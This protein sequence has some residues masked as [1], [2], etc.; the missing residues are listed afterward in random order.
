MHTEQPSW[1]EGLLRTIIETA[2]EAFIMV[3]RDGLILEFNGAAERTF[4]FARSE[5]LGRELATTIMPERYRA[6]HRAGLRRCVETGAGTIIGQRIELN[7]LHRDGD[8]F[9]VELTISDARLTGT[10]TGTGPGEVLFHAF[11]HDISER[12]LSERVLLATQAMTQA[13]AR[14]DSPEQALGALLATLGESMGWVVGAYWQVAPDGALERMASWSDESTRVDE[15]EALSAELR[16]ARD[17]GLPGR[18]LGRAEPV[19]ISDFAADDSF[20]RAQAA[21]RASLHAAI[22]VPVLR[23]DVIGVIE[24]FATEVR[25]RDRSIS[26]ALA[27]VGAQIG[28]LLGLLEERQALLSSLERMALTDQLTGL[29][30][31]RAWE[32]ALQRELARAGRDGN[33]VCVAVLDLDEFKRFNDD[34]GHQ[35]GDALLAEAAHSWQSQLRATDVLARY[36]GEE[37]AAVIPAWPLETAVT[38]VERLREATPSGLTASA[39]VASWN[40][41]ET[42]AELFGRADAALYQ[43]KQS[44]RNRTVAVR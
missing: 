21:H 41:E 11:L 13:M 15:F 22:A 39:G 17:E 5:V 4:G 37:F 44:G 35:A 2:H 24:F 10:G 8:E 23:D 25:V 36:G 20:P 32:E 1:D 33:S 9:P 29:P 40:R 12:K 31:R 6:A 42:A 14:A 28:E 30:N 43:A 18:A 7:A 27:T 34:H 19:W 3:D 16:L 38:V 26:G